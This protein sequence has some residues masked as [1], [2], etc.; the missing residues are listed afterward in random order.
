MVGA[1][2]RLGGLFAAI[3]L[4]LFITPAALAAPRTLSRRF[5]NIW[6][7]VRGRQSWDQRVRAGDKV[8]R[9]DGIVEP[10]DLRPAA[11]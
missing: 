3:L 8:K 7:L 2:F 10:V 6:N 4:T 5:R 1:A 9:K 11:E